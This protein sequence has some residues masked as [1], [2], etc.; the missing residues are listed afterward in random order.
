MTSIANTRTGTG[1]F[2]LMFALRRALRDNDQSLLEQR[3]DDIDRAFQQVLE[4]RANAGAVRKEMEDRLDRLDDRELSK[5]KQLSNIEDLDI[6]EAVVEMN[7]AD[8]RNRAALDT[9]ARLL[10]PSLLNFLR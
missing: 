9:S 8:T 6:P 1:G 4:V 2:D 10:Q 7:L 3:L 5:V